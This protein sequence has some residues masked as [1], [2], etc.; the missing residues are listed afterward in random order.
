MKQEPNYASYY[1]DPCVVSVWLD[2]DKRKGAIPIEPEYL[3]VCVMRFRDG[4]YYLT[5]VRY[6]GTLPDLKE[7]PVETH[8]AAGTTMVE[9]LSNDYE[10]GFAKMVP[11]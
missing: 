5:A 7:I 10:S 2:V 4:A 1:N 8:Y 3:I 6:E 9:A 11:M